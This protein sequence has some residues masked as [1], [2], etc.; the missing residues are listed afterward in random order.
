MALGLIGLA[1][2]FKMRE[3][4]ELQNQS[5]Q[6]KRMYDGIGVKRKLISNPEYVPNIRAEPPASYPVAATLASKLA[7]L[8][9]SWLRPRNQRLIAVTVAQH[10]EI[11]TLTKEAEEGCRRPVA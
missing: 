6:P 7:R 11:S 1:G 10:S 5:L 4:W 3:A 8:R 9:G 2:E